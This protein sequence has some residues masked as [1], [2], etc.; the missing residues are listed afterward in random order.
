MCMFQCIISLLVAEYSHLCS[1]VTQSGIQS[2]TLNVS[3]SM[4]RIRNSP[5]LQS[6]MFSEII[7]SQKEQQQVHKRTFPSFS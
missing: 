1:T 7:G 2:R 6:K 5:M 3:F 4:F